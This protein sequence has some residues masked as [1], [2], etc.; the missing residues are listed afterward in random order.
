MSY[1]CVF[2][3]SCLHCM[4][5][6]ALCYSLARLALLVFSSCFLDPLCG[7]FDIGLSGRLLQYLWSHMLQGISN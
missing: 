5:L 2:V 4:W 3:L 6:F 7:F 1:A